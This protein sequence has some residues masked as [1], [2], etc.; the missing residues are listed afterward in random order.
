MVDVLKGEEE[1]EEEE[2]V[3]TGVK[4]TLSAAE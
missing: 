3:A 4:H 2:E 1:E